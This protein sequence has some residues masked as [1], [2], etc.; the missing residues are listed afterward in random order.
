MNAADMPETPANCRSPSTDSPVHG[1]LHEA[2]WPAGV[3]H[4]LDVPDESLW[5]GLARAAEASPDAFG[6]RFLGRDWTWS[7]LRDDAERLA[8]ALQHLGVARG[9][10]VLLFSQNC[11]QYV[12]AF[13]AVLRL[14]AVVV[15]LNPM[16][17]ADELGHCIAD[18]GARVAIASADIAPE[19]LRASDGLPAENRLRHAVLFHLADA[20]PPC[21]D[22]PDAAHAAA[23]EDWPPAWR[24][25]L[26]QRGPLPASASTTVL[27]WK[28][29]VGEETAAPDAW[30]PTS[31]G[32]AGGPTAST[33]LPDPMAFRGHELA[34]L[35]YTSGTTGLP[36]GCCHTHASLLHNAMTAGPWLGLKPGDAQLVVVPMFHITGLVMGMLAAIRHR[37][38]LVVLPR[39][40][41][42]MGARTIEQ[43]GI[44]HWPN[45]PTMVIDLLAAPDLDRFDLRSLRYIGGGG[46]AMPEAVSARLQERFGLTYLEGSG[47]TE[48]A[49]PTHTNPPGAVRPRCLGIPYIGTRALI[50]D[51]QSLRPLPV[52][53]VGEI[54]VHG[55]QLFQGY[56]NQ[57]E[58][59]R[60][61]FVEIQGR[62][63]FRTGDLG[64]VDAQGYFHLADRL[65]RMIN[66]SGFKVWPAEVEALL[67]HH[68]DVQEAC[69]IRMQDSYRGESVK[70]VV[71]RR[72]DAKALDEAGL[73]AWAR[74]HM[75]AY[76]VPRAVRFAD[77]LPRSAS[78]KVLWRV[79]QEQEDAGS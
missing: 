67:L 39:W 62:R 4:V 8:Q 76:K 12:I 72:A 65:K 77:A 59:T 60:A 1:A 52:E 57:P 28:A 42:G 47:L 44:T 71:V 48:T 33:A 15:P 74:E 29:V 38:T 70:A 73:I 14:G 3:P 13:H 35:P 40:D 46:V 21:I 75:A 27:A 49:A 37:A 25:W 53:E 41:R 19:L 61:A 36:K 22:G 24:T 2:V 63:W 34:L 7:A 69:V 32:A 64:R 20:L 58:A 54:L 79:L 10:R 23:Y 18:P 17:K 30:E 31:T 66:A 9:D 11:P 43:A 5:L 55:P 45:V 56:W 6:L 50:V 68:P 26:T 51:P 78:G 16:N